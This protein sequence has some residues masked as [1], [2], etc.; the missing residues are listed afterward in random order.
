MQLLST[1]RFSR[2]KNKSLFISVLSDYLIAISHSVCFVN[3]PMCQF[4]STKWKVT[5]PSLVNNNSCLLWLFFAH[6]STFTS[7]AYHFH[8]SMYSIDL[9]VWLSKPLTI[10][11]HIY[12]WHFISHNGW[13][14]LWSGYQIN[15]SSPAVDYL[16]KA[17]LKSII[18]LLGQ[19]IF[20]HNPQSFIFSFF[21]TPQLFWRYQRPGLKLYCAP[22]SFHLLE[23]C[24]PLTSGQRAMQDRGKRRS[25]ANRWSTYKWKFWRNK[26]MMK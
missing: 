20:H 18:S 14:I 13:R 17:S 23:Y 9:N 11:L 3:I 21:C 26:N 12:V 8:P 4:Q 22:R 24:L 5:E 15:N 10:Q 25:L 16:L 7:L 1:A 19:S 6:T 2:R